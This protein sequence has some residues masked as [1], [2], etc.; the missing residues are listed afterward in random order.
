MKRNNIVIAFLLLSALHGFS[1]DSINTCF[2][3]QK[4]FIDSII[5]EHQKVYFHERTIAG[6]DSVIHAYRGSV[7]TD[8]SNLIRKVAIEPDS[9]A[10]RIILFCEHDKI[11]SILENGKRFYK[12]K[13]SFYNSEGNKETSQEAIKRFA[14]YDSILSIVKI[15]FE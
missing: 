9:S 7:V 4:R 14:A 2:L 13:D 10:A 6:I 11:F 1:Q 3:K 12:I 8:Q 5:L 15:I